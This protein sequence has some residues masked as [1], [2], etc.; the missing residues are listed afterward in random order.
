MS[1]ITEKMGLNYDLNGSEIDYFTKLNENTLKIDAFLPLCAISQIPLASL[2][3]SPSDGDIYIVDSSLIYIR[4]QGSWYT[5]NLPCGITFYDQ[6]LSNFYKYDG[7]TISLLDPT[8]LYP[9]GLEGYVI[10]S[11]GG[12]PVWAPQNT[13]FLDSIKINRP[14]FQSNPSDLS[15]IVIPAS[16]NKNAIAR[17]GGVYYTNTTDTIMDIDISGLGGLDTGTKSANKV[18]YLYG[19]EDTPTKF[20]TVCSIND[21]SV[22]PTGFLNW[23][24]FG[25]FITDASS[26][27]CACTYT[28]GNFNFH[29]TDGDPYD[30]E[31][32]T[33]SLTLQNI[34]VSNIA[35][36]VY[37]RFTWEIVDSIGNS[38]QIGPSNS[39]TTTR[40][41]ARAV[42]SNPALC[43]FSLSLVPILTPKTVWTE[44]EGPTSKIN[45][46]CFGWNEN[47]EDYK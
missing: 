41:V 29:H 22:G 43:Q 47:P 46:L 10:T 19:V 30:F 25:S 11:V 16:A 36:S 31:C 3:V 12:F 33:T 15:E 1:A 9:I 38:F 32:T 4:Q 23:T 26:N 7:T 20:G 35:K 14:S 5:F 27:I 8:G 18:Y 21:P 44:L 40:G 42:N 6:A 28:N 2:P 39:S 24:Y 13:S 17:I 37:L 45:C 34:N